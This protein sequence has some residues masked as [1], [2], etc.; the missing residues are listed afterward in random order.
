MNLMVQE[1]SPKATQLVKDGVNFTS[2]R[3]LSKSS[4]ILT[5]SRESISKSSLKSEQSNTQ[6]GKLKKA[7]SIFRNTY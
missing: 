4:K 3:L 7:V 6:K 1:K 2:Q 5:A